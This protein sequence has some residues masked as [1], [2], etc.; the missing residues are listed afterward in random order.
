MRYT[1]YMSNKSKS[2]Q[3]YQAFSMNKFGFVLLAVFMTLGAGRTMVQATNFNFDKPFTKVL[4]DSDEAE[5]VENKVENVETKTNTVGGSNEK[6]A[7]QR[8]E[9]AKKALEV[10]RE[11]QKEVEVKTK[12]GATIRVKREDNGQIRTELEKGNLHLKYESSPSGV[13]KKVESKKGETVDVSKNQ[14]DRVENQVK[15]ELEKN[16]LEISTD[17]NEAKVKKAGFEA[18]TVYPLSVGDTAKPL[19]VSTPEGE[20]EVKLTPDQVVKQLRVNG[21]MASPA[22]TLANEAVELK[23]QDGK[24]VYEVSGNRTRRL[25]GLFAVSQPI[26]FVVSADT[27]EV[28]GTKQSFLANLVSLLSAK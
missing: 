17:K 6:A 26:Q 21:Q 11:R 3:R 13:V 20:K 4:G 9:A 12:D 1:E 2:Y 23:V 18:S 5:K 10:V 19:A 24:P 8:S 27:G 25:L 16:D 14:L 22:G 7:E 28:V 15:K